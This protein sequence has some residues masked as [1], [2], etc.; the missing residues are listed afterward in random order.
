MCI[1]PRFEGFRPLHLQIAGQQF[2]HGRNLA[3]Y[4]TLDV[5]AF[6]FRQF[7]TNSDPNFT[8]HS[9]HSLP[10]PDLYLK[11][12]GKTDTTWSKG[13]A[14]ACCARKTRSRRVSTHCHFFLKLHPRLRVHPI[15]VGSEWIQKHSVDQ[16][17][18]LEYYRSNRQIEA[19]G[20][21]TNMLH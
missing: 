20:S 13:Q 14:P 21:T 9:Q 11:E 2:V 19:P 10:R 18:H 6:A 4:C 1:S 7:A 16:Y 8:V 17:Y 15:T 12:K 3:Q 5:N